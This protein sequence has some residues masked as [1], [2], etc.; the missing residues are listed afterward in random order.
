MLRPH[1]DLW[2]LVEQTM[3]QRGLETSSF[4]KVKAHTEESAIAQG[5]VTE[6]D[7]TNNKHADTAAGGAQLCH[8]Q[9][10]QNQ[11]RR[12]TEA[13]WNDYKRL[14]KIIQL[15]LVRVHETIQEP[16]KLRAIIAPAFLRC[17]V[18]GTRENRYYT[19]SY[20][21]RSNQNTTKYV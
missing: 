2:A 1:G 10:W 8:G 15:T 19:S 6:R 12:L 4:H 13:R 20:P 9:E 17:H 14:V 5:I 11:Y 16:R 18:K 7:R 21:L 3:Q